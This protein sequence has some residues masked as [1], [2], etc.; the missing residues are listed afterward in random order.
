MTVGL[1]INYGD[2]IMD[3]T[4]NTRI[5]SYVGRWEASLK[6]K[7]KTFNIRGGAR[8]VAMPVRTIQEFSNMPITTPSYIWVEGVNISGGTASLSLSNDGSGRNS[9]DGQFL[10]DMYQIDGVQTAGSV[11]LFMRDSSDVMSITDATQVSQ[12]IMRTTITVSTSYALGIPSD[13]V[14]FCRWEDSSGR[15]Y[16]D[17]DSMTLYAYGS[18]DYSAGTI[19]VQ[20]V[21]FRSQSPLFHNGGLNIW[22][23]DGSGTLVFST[24]KP[25]L[26]FQDSYYNLP[27]GKVDA[28]VQPSVALS[29]PMVCMTMVGVMTG[30]ATM[31]GGYKATFNLGFRMSGSAIAAH[32]GKSNGGRYPGDMVPA[33]ATTPIPAIDASRYF[34]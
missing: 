5:M 2:Y 10:F 3:I 20:I 32:I 11:G 28:F 6:N 29:K 25:P 15:L 8:L 27:S 31:N 30:T 13:S 17:R 12:C 26:L 22:K 4:T 23:G 19:S 16:L 34:S 18:G 14:V 7:S 1:R 21:A 33:V 9:W 24:E